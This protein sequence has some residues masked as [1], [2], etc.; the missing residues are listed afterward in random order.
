MHDQHA[1]QMQ[2]RDIQ[3]VDLMEM[4]R[5][6]IWVK[7]KMTLVSPP[8][9]Q[10]YMELKVIFNLLNNKAKVTV[11]Q[12]ALC[13]LLELDCLSLALLLMDAVNLCP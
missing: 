6:N 5:Q 13:S 4:E 7:T 9:R 3:S 8:R 1:I 11:V 10:L 12:G 2:T